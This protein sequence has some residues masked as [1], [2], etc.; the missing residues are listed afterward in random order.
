MHYGVSCYIF[1]GCSHIKLSY[2]LPNTGEFSNAGI[3]PE[4]ILIYLDGQTAINSLP[5]VISASVLTEKFWIIQ[6]RF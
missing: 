5:N 6:T 3:F 4:N 1:I 2:R